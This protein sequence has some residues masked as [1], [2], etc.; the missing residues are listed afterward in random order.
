[1]SKYSNTLCKFVWHCD[2]VIVIL[3]L[4]SL[5]LDSFL[6]SMNDGQP[7]ETPE[8]V[9]AVPKFTPLNLTIASFG[10]A[11]LFLAGLFHNSLCWSSIK[12]FLVL[13]I[14]NRRRNKSRGNS[15]ILVG[16][17]DAGKTSILSSVSC[18]ATHTYDSPVSASYSSCMDKL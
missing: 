3:K 2:V 13:V 15:L 7:H 9:S 8:V 11:F 5:L 16:P 14:L 6:H 17:P 18:I 12:R 1:M 4:F 10:A